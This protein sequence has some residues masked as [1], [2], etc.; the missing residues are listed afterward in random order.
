MHKLDKD[1]RI[2]DWSDNLVA[3]YYVALKRMVRTGQ[4]CTFITGT[5]DPLV[6]F[7]LAYILKDNHNLQPLP[8]SCLSEI[9]TGATGGS[10]VFARKA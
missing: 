1:K 8:V 3:K 2:I 7:C 10:E 9:V 5:H 4:F 6:Q